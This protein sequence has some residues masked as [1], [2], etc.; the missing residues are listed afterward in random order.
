MLRSWS[1]LKEDTRE[2]AYESLC[3]R[4]RDAERET[5]RLKGQVAVHRSKRER[6]EAALGSLVS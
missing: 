2:G 6:A 1:S 5:V 4:V 3:V